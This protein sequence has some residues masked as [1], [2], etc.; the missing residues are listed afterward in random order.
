MVTSPAES[1]PHSHESWNGKV[2]RAA[3]LNTAGT[4]KKGLG[5]NSRVKCFIVY[6][7]SIAGNCSVHVYVLPVADLFFQVYT[8]ME[9]AAF[10]DCSSLKRFFLGTLLPCKRAAK[11][12]QKCKGFTWNQKSKG[13]TKQDRPHVNLVI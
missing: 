13:F 1:S 4:R 2:T 7:R 3:H 8:E 9:A 6:L 12:R 5:G 10:Q 11:I